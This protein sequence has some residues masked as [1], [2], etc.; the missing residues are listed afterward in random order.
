MFSMIDK[1][2]RASTST[3]RASLSVTTSLTMRLAR[4]RGAGAAT[5]ANGEPRAAA[6]RDGSAR[7][8]RIESAAAIALWIGFH[9][10]VPL[11]RLRGGVF[12]GFR[13][14][15]AGLCRLGASAFIVG[16]GAGDNRD[17]L[18]RFEREV[19]VLE[20]LQQN[21]RVLEDV[22]RPL[23]HAVA[24][25]VD[26]DLARRLGLGRRGL[27]ILLVR[28][29][30]IL[31]KALWTLG[32][33]ASRAWAGAPRTRSQAAGY[34]CRAAS[35]ALCSSRLPAS[36]TS[37][38]RS[39][40]LPCQSVTTQPAPSRIGISGTMSYGFSWLSTTRSR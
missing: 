37:P 38:P 21:G 17:L 30:H 1:P 9:R 26:D 18:R 6:R 22:F 39:G 25:A 34:A 35:A 7:V 16:F 29:P 40:G 19:L 33:E 8:V 31:S 10:G 5:I 2:A 13:V 20:A 32:E 3:S 14:R 27:D 24:A 15:V 12:R 11:A 28:S 36:T 4:V 23:P